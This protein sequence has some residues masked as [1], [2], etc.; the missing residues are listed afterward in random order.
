MKHDL[1][2]NSNIICIV[3]YLRRILKLLYWISKHSLSLFLFVP[4]KERKVFCCS[5]ENISM[6]IDNGYNLK[7]NC[8][9]I[10]SVNSQFNGI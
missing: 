3:F 7:L 6:Q 1:S 5:N 8:K 10:K 4:K 2:M 9:K